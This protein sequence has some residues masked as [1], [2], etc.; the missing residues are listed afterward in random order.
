MEKPEHSKIIPIGT[1]ER[2][3]SRRMEVRY[4]KKLRAIARKALE[5][6]SGLRQV[7]VPEVQRLTDLTSHELYN[8]RHYQEFISRQ[9]TGAI[10]RPKK[11]PE[12]VFPQDETALYDKICQEIGQSTMAIRRQTIPDFF[13]Y[14]NW[15]SLSARLRVIV[16]DL[17]KPEGTGEPT[18][19][20]KSRA[21]R[22]TAALYSLPLAK[23]DTPSEFLEA[24]ERTTKLIRDAL[25]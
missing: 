3:E 25:K 7:V 5:D 16:N 21:S 22:L 6:L 15:H 17:E 4:L 1:D 24:I 18:E 2:A 14:N 23:F 10:E 8:H 19:Q 11:G 13:Q 9:P 12:L 20:I